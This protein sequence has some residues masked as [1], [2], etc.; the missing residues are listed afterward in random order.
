MGLTSTPIVWSP[1]KRVLFRFLF[2]YLLLYNL[3]FPLQ[4]V[5]LIEK[6]VRPRA[7]DLLTERLLQPYDQF[8]NWL[9]KWVGSHVFDVTI[10]VLPN[11]SGD[12]TYNYVQVFCFLVL[13]VAAAALWTF[14]ALLWALAGRKRT[15]YERLYDWLMIYVRFALAFTMITYGAIKV[16][17]SQFPSPSLDRLLQPF[18]DA[19]PMGLLWTFMGASDS[20]NFFSGA[21][22]LLGGLLLTTRRTTLLGALVSIGVLG[23]V[24]M[25]NFSYDVPVKLFSCHLLAM[26]VFIAAADWRRLAS[27]FLLNRDAERAD[28][29]PLFRWPWLNWSAAAVRTALVVGFT[30]MSLYG[31][32]ESQKTFGDAAPKSALYGIWNVEEF[33][34]DGKVLP[35]LL[36]NETR[37]RRVVFDYPKMIGIQL[38]SDSRRRYMLQLDTDN[39]KLELS[40]RDEPAWKSTLT[41]EQPEPESLRLRGKFDGRPLRAHLRLAPASPFLLVSRGFHWINEYPFN[42]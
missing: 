25:L 36:T 10:T 42:R 27:F 35:P 1:A 29:R 31:A 6:A 28:H 38:M 24:V 39:H 16:I 30:G 13:A 17:K 32:I 5:P 40:K 33:E 34:V 8:W 41:Y 19:S 18:G 7:S 12:T 3:P 21:G 26:A 37:W 14:L 11:G 4:F 22:E 23:N 2:A 20:Y 15:N 9:V